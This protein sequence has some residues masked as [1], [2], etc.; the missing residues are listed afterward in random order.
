MSTKDVREQLRPVLAERMGGDTSDPYY[1]H[2]A[3]AVLSLFPEIE[4]V[5][6]DHAGHWDPVGGWNPTHTR[7]VLK[8]APESTTT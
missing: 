4:Q 6:R 8:T 2:L 5:G 3:D 1:L 7:F